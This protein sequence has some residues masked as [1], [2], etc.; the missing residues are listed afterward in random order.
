MQSTNRLS[1]PAADVK[2]PLIYRF[3]IV[4]FR[5]VLVHGEADDN[6]G[7][8][9]IQSERFYSMQRCEATEVQCA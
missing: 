6:N 8:F 7:T 4:M 5:K 9:P 2:L 1:I 3:S